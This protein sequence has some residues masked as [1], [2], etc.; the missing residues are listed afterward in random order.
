M[1]NVLG[2]VIL[3]YSPANVRPANGMTV[4]LA[5]KSTDNDL[6]IISASTVGDSIDQSRGQQGPYYNVLRPEQMEFFEKGFRVY[7]IG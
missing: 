1:K 3:L 5:I 2:P 6:F 7:L 4:R